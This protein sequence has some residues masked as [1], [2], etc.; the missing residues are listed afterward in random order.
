MVKA[1]NDETITLAHGNGGK[2]THQLITSMF[3][4]TFDTAELAPLA[5]SACLKID[6]KFA[7]RIVF[8]TDSHVVTPIFFPGGDIGKL[9]VT[10]TVNDLAVMG[11][12]PLF[13]SCAFIIE[14]GFQT[15]KLKK[16][17]ESMAK[18][19]SDIGVK[20]VTGDTKVVEKGS[21]DGLFINTSGIGVMM[22]GAPKGAASIKPGDAVIISGTIG[23]HGIAIY[24]GREGINLESDLKSD[25]A[26]VAEL[27]DIA[28]GVCDSIRVM[29]DPTR[30]GLATTLNEF[31]SNQN[32]GIEVDEEALPIKSQ[33]AATCELL[34]FD[35]LYVANEGKLVL[36]VPK[37][38]ASDVLMALR[39]LRIGRDAALIGNVTTRAPGKV[40]LKT[41][42]G[43]ERILDMLVGDMLPRIC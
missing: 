28:M 23:D 13:L 39:E 1:K 21:A 10:G 29:R 33:V 35:P 17:V 22:E 37:E 40:Y 42:V 26:S 16:I 25:C 32:F 27:V 11:A 43:G 38:K 4:N 8:T 19:A 15:A 41:S 5:D 2:L 12:K 30:G 20:I 31:T 7:G 24:S 6:P 34:G 36:V 14:E 9:S 18:T 3:A